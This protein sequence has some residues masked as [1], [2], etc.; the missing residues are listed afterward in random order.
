M[1]LF[2]R[3]VGEGRPLIILHGLFGMSDNWLTH[4]RHY[5]ELG[6]EVHTLDQ[7]NH[8]QSAHSTD[9]SY[10]IM[11]EDVQEYMDDHS[12]EKACI[13][14]H[15]MGG[16]VA[17]LFACQHPEKVEKLLVIDIAP[18]AYP[19]H[20]Q[21]YIDAMRTLDFELLKS[22]SEAD[23]ALGKHIENFAIRQFMLKS[24]YWKEKG[25]LAFRF[26]L[27]A[28]EAN[29]AMVGEALLEDA[30]YLGDTLFVRGEESNYVLDDDEELIHQHF[31]L[32]HIYTVAGAGHWVHAEA[33]EEFSEV[34]SKFL[35][36][37]WV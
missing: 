24:L 10:Q 32:A 20:H 1:K 7:R 4:A 9:F 27:D 16:K 34:T 21:V 2:S 6:F 8:G 35:L 19:I 31:P 33:A 13:L 3:I 11:A 14:G 15:S 23:R 26:N 5:A 22:R 29:L 17:M 37:M 25:R 28:I 36:G 30:E 12:I 18:K